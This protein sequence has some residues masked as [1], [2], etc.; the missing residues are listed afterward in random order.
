MPDLKVAWYFR[1]KE[2]NSSIMKACWSGFISTPLT[3]NWIASFLSWVSIWDIGSRKSSFVRMPTRWSSFVTTRHDMS[4]LCIFF[5]ASLR[6][7]SVWTVI[8]GFTIMP[9]AETVRKGT[10]S[11]TASPNDC[12]C[13]G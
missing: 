12:L 11:P 5:S 8:T 7:V 13:W 3:P 9:L 2:S 1:V 10:F 4:C 6:G